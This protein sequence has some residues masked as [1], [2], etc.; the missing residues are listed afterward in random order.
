M[1][2]TLTFEQTLSYRICIDPAWAQKNLV[3]PLTC[4]SCTHIGCW[5]WASLWRDSKFL[6]IQGFQSWNWNLIGYPSNQVCGDTIFFKSCNTSWSLVC[7]AQDPL[8]L[9]PIAHDTAAHLC[10]EREESGTS[11]FPFSRRRWHLCFSFLIFDFTSLTCLQK[12]M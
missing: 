10:T 3:I 2:W 11:D 5:T 1:K 4:I 12:D 8:V 6:R 7:H 9:S